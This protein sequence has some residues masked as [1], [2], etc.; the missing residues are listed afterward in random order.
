[1]TW[2]PKHNAIPKK[3]NT[4]SCYDLYNYKNTKYV[5]TDEHIDNSFLKTIKLKIYPTDKQ[6]NIINQWFLLVNKVYNYTNNYIKENICIVDYY[7]NNKNIIDFNY[8]FI[9]DVKKIK[10]T[11]NFFNLRKK[12]NDFITDLHSENNIN[13]H[14][15][16]YSLKLCVEMYKSLYSNY[17]NKH[18]KHF[19]VKDLLE[20]R[21]R[22]NLTLEPC[23]FN[24]KK[25]SFCYNVLGL[26]KSDKLFN[27]LKLNHNIILQFDKI[28]KNYYLLIPVDSKNKIHIFREDKCGVDIGVRTFMTVYSKNKCV[29]IGKNICNDIDNFN[30]KL[31]KLKSH[32]ELKKITESK[33]NKTR[34]KYQD[35]INNK[36]NDMHK[37]V[38]TFLLK[39]YEV[40]NIGKV[41]IKNMTSNLKGNIKDITKRRLLKLSHYRFREY[42]KL[43]S[44]KYGNTINEIDEYMTSKTCHNCKN[45]KRDLGSNKT[46]NCDNCNIKLDRDINASINIYNL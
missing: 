10:E 24:K 5:I 27:S 34:I 7:V 14:T 16:D 40:I 33:Y 8:K 15:L 4:F 22:F 6:A 43:N 13:R 29:E 41:S 39:N 44:L 46:Y 9:N 30:N 1:M 21:R 2:F 35:K 23:N 17:K 31:D 20:S 12:L 18:I 37:K 25:N 11:L 42:L 28:K 26:M 19:N 3:L 45:I 36:I 38:S 32:L